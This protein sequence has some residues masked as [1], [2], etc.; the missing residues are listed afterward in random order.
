MK[1]VSQPMEKYRINSTEQLTPELLLSL[2]N[3]YKL[4]EVPRL[5]RLYRYYENNSD[6]KQRTMSD[7]SKPNNRIATPFPNYI[8]STILG[9]FLG[10]PVTYQ[11]SNP[12]LM[13]TVQ[14]IFDTNEEQSHNAK[15][16]VNQSIYGIGYELMF[17]NEE[18]EVKF[19]SL[20]P[21]ETFLI[22][23]TSIISKPIAG[24]RFFDIQDYTS[25]SLT[26]Y[27]EVY[28]NSNIYHYRLEED[29]LLLFGEEVHYFN[30]VPILAYENSDER[31]GDYERVIDLIDA[32]DMTISDQQNS[33]EYFADSY[34]LISGMDINDEDIRSMKEN[35]VIITD[36]NGQASF[37]V[38]DATTQGLREY[39]NTLQENIHTFSFV[40]DMSDEKFSNASGESLKYK[41]LGLENAVS[42]KE[43][44]FK[45]SLEERI[46][47]IVNFLNLKGHN[48][49]NTDVV[50]SF[51]RNM[52]T[53]NSDVVEMVTK[54]KGLISDSSLIS[55][56]PFVEDT[57]YELELL[58]Q[59]NE[60]SINSMGTY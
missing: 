36:E 21:T 19:N 48:Y 5:K 6:I 50:V 16:G 59:Q 58:K 32:F 15:L 11:S 29:E 25:E 42:I 27:V 3:R 54:L 40:P 37:L 46:R 20:N 38:K 9:Y 55:L 31:F 47:L 10:K 8:T 33:L 39:Q 49:D 35:R 28:T 60:D 12:N 26:M 2:V 52:P 53:N 44:H 45:Q 30:A 17:L 34:L 18:G 7:K 22:Y 13:E 41:L 14:Y 43:R 4:K 56:L 51:T 57:A 1:E 23:D 24:V